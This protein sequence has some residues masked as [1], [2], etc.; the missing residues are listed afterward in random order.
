MN[1]RLAI[2]K[3]FSDITIATQSLRESVLESGDQLGG[4]LEAD[5]DANEITTDA[6]AG[7]PF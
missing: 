7:G 5:G 4:I 1:P 2:I 3:S 6:A